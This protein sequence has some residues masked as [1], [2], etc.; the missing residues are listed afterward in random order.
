L[1]Q[2]KNNIIIEDSVTY[3]YLTEMARIAGFREKIHFIPST[4]ESNIPV[5]MNILMGW[6]LDFLILLYDSP[7]KREMA[8]HLKKNIFLP[9]MESASKKI[10]MMEGFRKVEDLFSTIDFKRFILQKRTGITESNSDY[11]DNNGLSRMIL[12]TSFLNHIRNEK[13]IFADFDAE[14]QKN[15]TLLFEKIK[16]AIN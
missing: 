4:H 16:K 14:T 2:Q 13:T 15:F 10:I 9:A 3:Y 11:I 7:E 6:R 1:I 5:L 12:V 8:E